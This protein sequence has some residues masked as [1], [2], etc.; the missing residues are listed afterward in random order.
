MGVGA[1]GGVGS[2]EASSFWSA[3]YASLGR[4]LVSSTFGD[5]VT[6]LS[7]VYR[8]WVCGGVGGC[9]LVVWVEVRVVRGER[10]RGEGEEGRSRWSVS[11]H[12]YRSVKPQS[13][14]ASQCGASFRHAPSTAR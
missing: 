3:V 12:V 7:Q 13:I 2:A 11:S 5:L 14:R 4:E 9:E 6:L 10:E 8:G 1:E